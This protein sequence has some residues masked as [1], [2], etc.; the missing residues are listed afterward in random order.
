MSKKVLILGC[1]LTQGSYARD[2]KSSIKESIVSSYGWYDSL[3]CLKDL[4]IDVFAYGG[5]GYTTFAETLNDLHSNGK[6]KDYSMLIIQETSEP[7]FVLRKQDFSWREDSSKEIEGRELLIKH[8][9]AFSIPPQSVFSKNPTTLDAIC[10]HHYGIPSLPTDF[11]LDILESIT[12]KNLVKFSLAYINQTIEQ[13]NLKSF[14]FSLFEP[15]ANS[16]NLPKATRLDL[17]SN[18]YYEIKN[19]SLKNLSSEIELPRSYLRHFSNLG[20]KKLGEII[21]ESLKKII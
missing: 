19:D 6:L 21:N 9:S 13:Y 4:E 14:V 5:G 10:E 7:R 12:Y 16:E 15:H 8:R 3:K 17:P 20:N 1:S 2:E 11:K 18:L